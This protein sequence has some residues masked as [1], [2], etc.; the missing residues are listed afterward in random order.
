[1][2]L[3]A[4]THLGPYEILSPLGA[5]GMGEVYRA[6]DTRLGREVAV[7]VLP[8]AFA[9]DPD[10]LARFE[11]EA[12]VLASLNHPNIV[13][14]FSVE[15]DADVP[16]LVM[17]LV[18]GRPLS[19]LI[20]T[21][22]LPTSRLLELAIPMAEALAAANGRGVIHRDLKPANVVVGEG[23][24]VKVIDFG[25]AKKVVSD[26]FSEQLSA[27][28]T[29]GVG[30]RPLTREAALEGTLHYMAPEQVRG[31]EPD[32]RTDVFSL[33]VVLYEMAAGHRPFA[34]SSQSD[35]V[36]AILRDAPRP[37]S[38]IAPRV[39]KH[40]AWLVGRCLEKDLDRRLQTCRDVRNELE[41]LRLSLR[42]GE[43]DWRAEGARPTGRPGERRFPL[44]TEL[45]RQLS[46]R[47]PR[48]IGRALTYLDNG[49]DSKTLVV[50][51]HGTGGDHR[52]F[53]P[54]LDVLPQRGIAPT[55]VGFEVSA[56]SRPALGIGDHGRILRAFL[57][58]LHAKLRPRHTILVGF[59]CGG[60]MW[61]RLAASEEGVGV[62]VS[63]LVALG[64]NV[65]LS[66][67]FVTGRFAAM[68]A[69]DPARVLSILKSLGSDL[70][71]LDDWL[72]LQDYIVSSFTKL[73]P[74]LA[75]LERWSSDIVAPFQAEAD[76]LARWF[77]SASERIPNV[78]L[79][80]SRTEA[81]EAEALLARHLEHNVL[82][83][84]FSEASVAVEP[85]QHMRLGEP[86]LILRV[87]REAVEALGA[88]EPASGA[89]GS[90]QVEREAN[91]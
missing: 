23:G 68:N 12:R 85:V 55:L 20:P 1:M 6:K 17:E 21:G 30:S 63:G 37:L 77:R 15:E 26:G 4:G 33:G 88:G 89:H 39:P 34:G 27:M 73:G 50:F 66:N 16:Y 91:A 31:R 87:V 67:C 60:E 70:E 90:G 2:T 9:K 35:L 22:G 24:Q 47:H 48:L 74:D 10:R 40:L 25:L 51:L 46:E 11:R 52:R 83:P 69:S 58:D 3:A 81:A 62:P 36:S 13:T 72:A 82:G 49:A 7:K 79:V 71:G 29:E 54:V 56:A 57:Q 18:E 75:V 41:D 86:G 32:G 19:S 64:P 38:E 78:R 42:A 45:V 14:I 61:L 84:N 76:P 65:E 53:E 43:G 8:E 5:G 28:P 59:S 80:F 44:S